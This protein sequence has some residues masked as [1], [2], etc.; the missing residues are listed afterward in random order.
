MNTLSHRHV[1]L[2]MA[3]LPTP[4]LVVDVSTTASPS[5]SASAIPPPVHQPPGQPIILGFTLL[6]FMLACSA[7]LLYRHFRFKSGK[8]T[9]SSLHAPGKEA[10]TV[11]LPASTK[12]VATPPSKILHSYSTIDFQAASKGNTAMTLDLDCKAN[13]SMSTFASTAVFSSAEP[14]NCK[15]GP[16][17][18]QVSTIIELHQTDP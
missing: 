9:I 6:V 15:I 12:F 7:Y 16:S 18:N 13:V 4:T 17:N 11:V 2:S 3:P 1:C 14:D 5:V 8:K 10:P